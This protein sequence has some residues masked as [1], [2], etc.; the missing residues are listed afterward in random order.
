MGGHVDHHWEGIGSGRIKPEAQ[1][2]SQ[3]QGSKK[4]GNV[5]LAG[6]EREEERATG[7]KGDT[8]FFRIFSEGGWE[9]QPRASGE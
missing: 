6:E 2:H 9:S 4:T 3:N 1:S 7:E 5:N 8:V